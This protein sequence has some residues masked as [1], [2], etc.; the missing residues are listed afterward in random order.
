MAETELTTYYRLRPGKGYLKG[1]EVGPDEDVEEKDLID[2]EAWAKEDIDE[3]LQ[4]RWPND[5]ALIP[6]TIQKLAHQL[7]AAYVL[8]IVH[9]NEPE[10]PG[11]AWRK[12]ATA[13]LKEIKANRRAIK[14]PD[15]SWDVDFPGRANTEEG[16]QGGMKIL[17]L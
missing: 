1:V 9:R 4:K 2:A 11:Q 10:H 7:A 13:E 14:H 8:D 12:Q 5:L 17:S 16:T 6:K 15:G 3:V